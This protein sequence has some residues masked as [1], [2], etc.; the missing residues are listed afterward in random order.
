[1][2]AKFSVDSAQ[3]EAYQRNIER[4]PN[5]AE[6]IINENLK[7]KIS[8]SMQKIYPGIHTYFR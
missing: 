6:K 8:P 7:K 2:S 3:F 1:M 4:L 5:V